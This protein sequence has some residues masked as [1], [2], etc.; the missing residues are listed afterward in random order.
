PVIVSD[1]SNSSFNNT[2]NLIRF[3][4]TQT[5]APFARKIEAEFARSVLTP[6]WSLELDLSGLLRGDPEQRWQSWKIAVD[7]GILDPDEVRLEEG[8]NPRPRSTAV[9]GAVSA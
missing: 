6:G 2:A 5:L 9:P 1:L 8:F 7:A 4:A 3:F